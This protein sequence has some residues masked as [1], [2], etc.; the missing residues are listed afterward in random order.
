MQLLLVSYNKI[1]NLS[2][3]EG[4]IPFKATV[5]L[6]VIYFA[7]ILQEL[8]FYISGQSSGDTAGQTDRSVL[9]PRLRPT[10]ERPR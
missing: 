5:F 6:N 4:V 9:V 10:P 3:D 8:A 7:F 1:N 2:W